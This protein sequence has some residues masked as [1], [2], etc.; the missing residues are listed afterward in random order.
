MPQDFIP[1]SKPSLT[2]SDIEP[3]LKILKSGNLVQGEISELI[4]RKFASYF[5]SKYAILVSSGTAALHLSLLAHGIGA[6]DEVIV[7]SYSFIATANS[8]RLAGAEPIFADVKPNQVN[9]SVESVL[10]CITKRTKA[11]IVVHE[12]GFAAELGAV[13]EIARSHNLVVIE[14]AACAV[15]SKAF[16]SFLG[17]FSA[18][19][20]F[21][22]HPRKIITCGEGGLI[23]TDNKEIM[24][25]SYSMRNHGIITTSSNKTYNSAGFNYRLTDFSASL[26]DKQLDRIDEIIARRNYVANFY[27]QNIRNSKITNIERE[28]Q[29]ICNWQTYPI[30]LNESED[31]E[32][33]IEN[34]QNMNISSIR[35]AQFIPSANHYLGQKAFE[36]REYINARNTWSRCVAIPIYENLKQNELERIVE[37][38]NEFR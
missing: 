36:K 18:V 21:S 25:F 1:I 23:V 24:Q 29:Q 14:D 15:G 35:P 8:V 30:L 19:G 20:C 22:F 12:F 4:E 26:L 6:G 33:F 7:P 28:S 9:I 34:L 10:R 17:T 2:D 16:G 31:V 11:I 3:V 13:Q 5:G 32:I 38:V 37:A 27:I